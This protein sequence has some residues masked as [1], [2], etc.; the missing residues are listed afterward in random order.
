MFELID[1]Y[2]SERHETSRTVS[3]ESQHQQ[4]VSSRE[5]SPLKRPHGVH[6]DGDYVSTNGDKN[7]EISEIDYARSPRKIATSTSTMQFSE[8]RNMKKSEISETTDNII[9]SRGIVDP[10][11][12]DVITVGE[13]ISRRILDVRT[14]RIATT[15]S[16]GTTSE[17]GKASESVSISDAAR[18]NL[19]DPELASRLLGP[20][21]FTEDGRRVSLLEAIQRELLD[22]E[23]GDDRVKVTYVSDTVGHNSVADAITRGLLDP[24]TGLYLTENN[25]TITIE[26]AYSRGYLVRIDRTVKIRRG[27]LA[28]ADA[29][30]QGLVDERQGHVIDR[31]TGD[32][33]SLDVAIKRGIIDPDVRE[34]VDT[35]NDTKI[36]VNDAI[37]EGIINPKIGKYVNDNIEKLS[38]KEARRRRLIV[39]PMTLKDCCDLEIIDANGKI[40]SPAGK[41]KITIIEAITIGVL[42]SDNVKSVTDTRSGE[43]LTLSEALANG[44][45]QH[46]GYFRDMLN[47]ELITIPQAVDRGLVTSVAQKSIFDIDGFKD[48]TSGE[49]VSFNRALLKGLVSPKNGGSF[50][51]DTDTGRTVSFNEAIDLGHARPEVMEMLNRGIGVT[52]DGRELSVVEAVLNDF[53]DPKS[54]QLLN[55]RTGQQVPLEE[56]IKRALITPD[57]AALLA[58]LLNITVTTQTVTKTIKKYVTITAAGETITR[59]YKISYNE[60]LER[61]LIDVKN[62]QFRDPDSGKLLEISA[63]IR[64]G[65]LGREDATFD[66]TER[67]SPKKTRD[68]PSKQMLF[69]STLYARVGDNSEHQKISSS[70]RAVGRTT[71]IITHNVVPS[72]DTQVPGDNQI[73]EQ[74][75][76]VTKVRVQPDRSKLDSH[77]LDQS[78]TRET[79]ISTVKT[80]FEKSRKDSYE[81]E[82]LTSSSSTKKDRAIAPVDSISKGSEPRNMDLD[83]RDV[84]TSGSNYTT[85]SKLFID[86]EVASMEKKV[87]ELPREGWLL[88]EAIEQHLFDPVTGLFIIPGTDRLVSFEECVKLEIINPNSAIVVDPNNGR[89]VS[90][91]RSLEKNILDS[92][93]HYLTPTKLSMKEAIA[94]NLVILEHTSVSVEKANPRLLQITRVTGQ[95]DRVEVTHVDDPSRATEI[96]ISEESFTSDPV[97]VTQGIIYDP[98]TALVIFTDTGKSANIL[99]AVNE[100]TL[101]SDTVM[102][103]DPKTGQ[104]IA[105]NEAIERNI[106]DRKT[107]DYTDSTGRKI[108]LMDAAKFG[109]VAVLGTPLVAAA[110]AVEAV[111]KAMVKDP[112][113]GETIPHEVAIERGL[114]QPEKPNNYQVSAKSIDL[115][116]SRREIP[117]GANDQSKLVTKIIS[118]DSGVTIKIHAPSEELETEAKTEIAQKPVEKLEV[119][120]KPDNKAAT[121]CSLAEK[122]RNRVT[123]EP[124]Y[125]VTIGR[126]R[127]ISQSPERDARPIVLQKM[128][129]RI[130]NPREA[131]ESGLIDEKTAQTLERVIP[132]SDG[133]AHDVTEIMRAQNMNLDDGKVKD[134]QSGDVISIREAIDRGILDSESADILVPLASSLS[135]PG[136]YKQGLLDRQENKVVHPETGQ[137]LSLNEAIVCEI[138][139]PVSKL[140][141]ANGNLTISRAIE[142]AVIDGDRSTVKVDNEDVN[143]V[144]A[145]ERNVFEEDKPT[146]ENSLSPL[147]MTFAL[148]VKR[149]LVDAEKREVTHPITGEKLSLEKAIENDFIMSL[150]HPSTS[151]SVDLTKAIED[152]LIDEKTSTFTHPTSGKVL[153][154][155]EAV[156][157]GLLIVESESRKNVN[158]AAVTETVTSYHTVTTKTVAVLPGYSLINSNQI[159]NTKTGEVIDISEAQ[160]RGIVKDESVTKEEFTTRH[161]NTTFSDAIEKNLLDMSSGTYKDPAS[162]ATMSIGEAIAAGI[163]DTSGQTET[164]RPSITKNVSMTILDAVENLYDEKTE[165]F[166]DPRTKKMYDLTEAMEIGLV[167]SDSMVY[168]V[169]TSEFVTT[170]EAVAK[171]LLD[172]KSGKM[173]NDGG[174]TMSVSEAAKLGLLAVVAAPILAG[175]C[176]VDAIKNRSPDEK[177]SSGASVQKVP[178]IAGSRPTKPVELDNEQTKTSEA[179]KSLAEPVDLDTKIDEVVKH[180]KLTQKPTSREEMD[181][182]ITEDGKVLR[183]SSPEIKIDA[184]I[185]GASETP[186]ESANLETETE[187]DTVTCNIQTTL[188]E[189][190]QQQLIE[191]TDCRIIVGEREL[192]HNVKESLEKQEIY[193]TDM[194]VILKRNTICLVEERT[195]YKVIVTRELTA[196]NLANDG[197]YDSETEKFVDPETGGT[198]SFHDFVLKLEILDPDNTW[199]KDLSSKSGEYVVLR[200]AINRP[201]LDRNSGYMV[202][203]KSGKKIPFFEAVQLGLIVHRQ[204][205]IDDD[206]LALSLEEAVEA[207]LCDPLNGVLQ[208][209]RSGQTMTLLKAV[210]A[211]LID[212]DTVSIRNPANDE[213]IPLYE[214]V[215]AGIVDLQRGVII[216]IETRT[217]ID[218]R[219]AFQRGL[220]VPGLRKPIALE[221]MI[222]KGLYDSESGKLQD[223]LTKQNIDIE[224]AVKRG[225]VDAFITEC[226]DTNAGTFISLD[227]ALTTNLVNP[228]IGRLR[229][230]KAGEYLPFDVALAKRLIV[231]TPF[232]PSLIDAIVQEYYSPKSG[233]VLNPMTGN[234]ITV[235]QAVAS[236]FVDVSRTRIKDE[237]R[238]RVVT[239]REAQDTRLMDLDKGILLCP[240][241]MSL[242]VAFEKGYILSTAKPWTLQ[243]ALAHQSYNGN[244]RDFVIDGER[245]SLEGAI[246]RGHISLDGPSIKDPRTGDVITLGD[247]IKHGLIDTKNGTAIDPSTGTQMTL[248][249]ALD[250]GLVVPAK[251]KISLPEAVFKGLYDPKTGQFTSVETRE[252]IPTDR[253]I[254]EGVIDS[255]SAIVRH[256]NGE[257]MTFDRA[258]K[259]KIVDPKSGRI[260]SEKGNPVDFHEALEQGIIL[261]TRRPMTFS[262]AILK[263]ILDPKTGLFLDSKTGAYMTL[264]RAIDKNIID[265]ESVYVK[266]KITGFSRRVT[267][268]EAVRMGNVDGTSGRVKDFTR[269]N[270]EISLHEA[271]DIGLV[272]DNKAAVSLQRAIHQGLY[273]DK[274]GKITDPSNGRSVTLH[275]AMRKCIISPKLACYWDKRG[276]SLLSLAETCRAG[277]IDRRSGMFKEPVAN[278]P[279]PLSLALQLGLI[280]DIESANFGLYEAIEMGLYDPPSGYF[281]HPSTNRKLT[282]AEA[283]NNE[284]VN[285][286][287]SIVKNTK[288]NKYVG[289]EEAIRDGIIDDTRG[290]YSIVELNRVM[291]LA[292]A[293][294]KGFIVPSKKPLSIEEAVKSGL[295]RGDSGKFVDPT[296]NEFYDLTQAL[297]SGL[298]DPETTALKDATSGQIKSMQDGIDDGTIDV[299]KGRVLDPKTKRS[300]N[301]D[302]ALERGLLVTID[303]PV[304]S[305]S[306][307][308]T[309][310]ELG[311]DPKSKGVRDCSIEEAIRY[312]LIDPKS[313]VVKDSRNARFVTLAKALEDEIVDSSLRAT[314]EPHQSATHNVKF[315]KFEDTFVYLVEPISFEKAV[316]NGW[317]NLENAKFTDPE[318]NE[319]LS[320]KDTF[321]RGVIDPDSALIKDRQKKKLVKLPEAFRKG[322]MDGEKGNILD[323]STSKLNNLEKAVEI[324]LLIT[325][326]QGIS[327]IE[328]LQF[329]LYN[330][331]TGS[332]NDPFNVTSVLDRKRLTLRDAIDNGLIDP[333]TTV[334]KDPVNGRITSLL[335]ALN[336]GR[337]NNA[338]GKFIEDPEGKDLDFVKALERGYI[339]AAEARVSHSHDCHVCYK[340]ALT[341]QSYFLSISLRA[342][343][344]LL[345][346]C[347]FSFLTSSSLIST[348]IRFKICFILTPF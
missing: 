263:G 75:K 81:S 35:K 257:L 22:A 99:A 176:V 238:D 328:A 145:V 159:Q 11:T 221:A 144:E 217:E 207:G 137:L 290:T 180:R 250:R 215:E 54:G 108:S 310:T 168:D 194:I 286:R 118:D 248:N 73:I 246:A 16:N 187:Q 127:S 325:Q 161:K 19:I 339:L 330:P 344:G 39:K 327:F 178:P 143:L 134:P 338:T 27:S 202:D 30:S 271:Y 23:R 204:P 94:R 76:N 64:E 305:S 37:R 117:S 93:G 149:G 179:P 262:E 191:P 158:V 5:S 321:A 49:F 84:K 233:L 193:L 318:T 160:K 225:I 46:D 153:S 210:E 154:I 228:Q 253:A 301:I 68:I 229:D 136:L 345:Q 60:A 95:P 100:G 24:E 120:E 29:I 170:K 285:P 111:K 17:G 316:E 61:N 226:K 313:C 241:S 105:I 343:Y 9:E 146:D 260:N 126:A 150:P 347:L 148:A 297:T 288:F 300:Y 266:D 70:P 86:Q 317:L 214:A 115:E 102:V 58:S 218:I 78:S 294:K 167:E 44:I 142:K 272:V 336:E 47:D 80:S 223:P 97:Q 293:R 234:E 69:E 114:V 45:I 25:E 1:R 52:Y 74:M 189:A 89:K 125:K 123:T 211:G 283:C 104:D 324:G 151:D 278:C 131:V 227:D 183:E 21:G 312:E 346:I 308:K 12:G 259:E 208:D 59:D 279:I 14:G 224:E 237:R 186:E 236:G 72:H 53:L 110:A 62:N 175:K 277:V 309:C 132:E 106:L 269:N 256:S 82:K 206:S 243:Q 92:T 292:E 156:E 282:L 63:A 332:F 181:H 284:L 113:T 220:V 116:D 66:Q 2:S 342:G 88:G 239:V 67:P 141:E 4:N 71:T 314:I 90:L 109:V 129:K 43:L 319:V 77:H 198:V 164:D 320:V 326:K 333:S 270:L 213:V 157:T 96:E 245:Q 196:E 341:Q 139:D 231:T 34:I 252:K 258:I 8:I 222:N 26:D 171:G 6:N 119:T 323:T 169:K 182:V 247:A 103:K 91:L 291:D 197:A 304:S 335:E 38:F 281:V 185:V 57:G 322:I 87:F 130:V 28:L 147:G 203:P 83:K 192:T 216:N 190:I 261:E 329:G 18:M 230:I 50:V 122:T 232:T 172:P 152:G 165:K 41:T 249:D 240:H 163:L 254:K 56:A 107:G 265:A 205:A 65:L 199:V 79:T 195:R 101:K 331:T 264:A 3:S 15:T 31:N 112:K 267:L 184:D 219:V 48:P 201:L 311:R 98:A 251:R 276:E 13:A 40:S 242:D 166:Q 155:D 280:V 188:G 7:R 273:D 209:P 174:A 306:E 334:I 307:R 55:P 296:I 340:N 173:K 244:T 287:L 124:K 268:M 289:L 299:P 85:E 32:S 298:L 10:N 235:S 302:V 275:E 315:I 133:E 51:V 303:R 20:C 337:I 212:P 255:T 162:G 274:T 42:D 135:V 348:T 128:R 295:Y 140:S 177:K 138:V 200:E 33:Y 36:T 121:T